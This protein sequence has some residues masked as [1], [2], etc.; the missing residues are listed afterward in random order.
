MAACRVGNVRLCPKVQQS[1]DLADRPGK[2]G[3]DVPTRIIVHLILPDECGYAQQRVRGKR[4]LVSRRYVPREHPLS[5]ILIGL[6]VRIR[7]LE[8]VARGEHIQVE[9]VFRA[10]LEIKAV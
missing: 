8:P 1:S 9:S 2:I 6:V 10:W 5:L 7:D 3:E 4:V